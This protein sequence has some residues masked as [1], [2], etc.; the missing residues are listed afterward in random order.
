MRLNVSVPD[1]LHRLVLDELPGVSPSQLLQEAM[2]ALL[3]CRHE[4]VRCSRCTSTVDVHER[5]DAALDRYYLDVLW[6]LHPLVQRGGTAEG[7]ARVAKS[8][9]ARH[10]IPA[11]RRAP[12]PG[13]S[14]AE[15]HGSKVREL[16]PR[17]P[18]PAAPSLPMPIVGDAAG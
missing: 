1:E 8:V 9:A 5:I 18:S 11:A 7:A 15:R 16:T 3:D 6:E 14:R 17:P 12:L 2:R 10:R 13:R 4:T